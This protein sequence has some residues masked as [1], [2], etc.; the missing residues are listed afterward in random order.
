MVLNGKVYSHVHTTASE[1]SESL[2]FNVLLS[3]IS[4]K[5]TNFFVSRNQEIKI[6]ILGDKEKV[7]KLDQLSDE[8]RNFMFPFC[9]DRLR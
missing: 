8:L 7:I 4:F 9:L 5:L 1:Y 6:T 3:F 2:I